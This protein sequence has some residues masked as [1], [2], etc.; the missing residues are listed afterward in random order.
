LIDRCSLSRRVYIKLSSFSGQISKDRVRLENFSFRSLKCRDF[1]K[2]VFSKILGR[3][4]SIPSDSN[5]FY[6]EINEFKENLNL[7]TSCSV[8]LG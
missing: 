7:G 2:R 5:D 8:F 6:W 4:D 1:S 3:F